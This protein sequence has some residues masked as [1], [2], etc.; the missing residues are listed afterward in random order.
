MG[1]NLP[2]ETVQGTVEVSL[3]DGRIEHRAEEIL[4]RPVFDL[5]PDHHDRNL[6]LAIDEAQRALA[7]AGGQEAAKMVD[8]VAETFDVPA[9]KERRLEIYCRILGELPVDLL[10]TATKRVLQNHRYKSLPLPNDWLRQ[11]EPDLN[12]RR[13]RVARFETARSKLDLARRLYPQNFR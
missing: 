2:V 1:A 13:N 11:V 9:P 3:K 10:H 7:P 4:L 6:I 8:L 12:K 5:T